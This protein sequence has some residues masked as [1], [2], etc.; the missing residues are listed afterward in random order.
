MIK[1]IIAASAIGFF[2]LT[3]IAFAEATDVKAPQTGDK[4]TTEQA[5]A[6]KTDEA[7]EAP[8]APEVK[9]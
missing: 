6:D 2:L 3:G 7:P 4:Q 5:P 1:K 8:K 9:K